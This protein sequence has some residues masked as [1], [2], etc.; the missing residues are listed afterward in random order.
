MIPE[1]M[2]KEVGK[3]KNTAASVEEIRGD[4]NLLA[5]EMSTAK[6]EM[7][8]IG[9]KVQILETDAS[10]VMQ[11]VRELANTAEGLKEADARLDADI[12]NILNRLS[13]LEG[14]QD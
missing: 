14:R 2:Q 11:T 10:D 7:S 12:R 9:E 6:K 5:G 1:T 3:Q 13:A 4:V 8:E